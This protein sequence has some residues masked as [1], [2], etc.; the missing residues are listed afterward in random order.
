MRKKLLGDDHPS[1]A[2]CANNLG[3][4]LRDLGRLDESEQLHRQAIA[5]AETRGMKDSPELADYHAQL[6]ACLT[7]QKRFEE[8][9]KELLAAFAVLKPHVAK[10]DRRART[11]VRNLANLYTA[12][13]KPDQANAMKALL[14]TTRQAGGTY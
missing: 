6:G 2:V 5:I 14:P 13:D 10:N 7:L 9:E 8:A 12:W 11:T 4:A 3:T 1:V